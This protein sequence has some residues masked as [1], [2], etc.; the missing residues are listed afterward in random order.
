MKFVFSYNRK[1]TKRNYSYVNIRKKREM[2]NILHS[3][4]DENMSVKYMEGFLQK[5]EGDKEVRYL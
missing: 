3:N 1:E 5:K 4:E 2:K